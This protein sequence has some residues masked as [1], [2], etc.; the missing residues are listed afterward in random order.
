MCV[1][2]CVGVYAPVRVCCEL[3]VLKCACVCV[4]VCAVC[5]RAF[6]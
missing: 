5:V 1:S 4:C 2:V 3:S 6:V